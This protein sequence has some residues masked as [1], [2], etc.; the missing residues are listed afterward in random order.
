[1][2]YKVIWNHGQLRR[3]A[4]V[5]MQLREEGGPASDVTQAMNGADQ[6][7]AVNPKHVGESRSDEE[8]VWYVPPLTITYEIHEEEKIV[9]VLRFHY[10]PR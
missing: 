3:L 5:Y 4:E 10:A 9:Y 6:I 8:R 2:N 7:L 1:M